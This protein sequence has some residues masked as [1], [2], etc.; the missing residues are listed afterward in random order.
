MHAAGDGRQLVLAYGAWGLVAGQ[1]GSV[2]NKG[3][4]PA[5]GAGLMKRLALRFV[6]APTP[7]HYTS[8]TC[9]KCGHACGPHATLKTK[10][11]KEIRG[12]RVCQHEGCGLLQNRD[13]AGA[14]NIGFNFNRLLCNRPPI[15]RMSGEELEFHRVNACLECGD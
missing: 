10:E 14:T 7:E 2:A 3:N 6:V 4:P 5:V 11:G 1:P 9:V 12:L 8:K 13:K 15:K